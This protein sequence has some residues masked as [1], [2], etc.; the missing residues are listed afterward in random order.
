MKQRKPFQSAVLSALGVL[1]FAVGPA[2]G[3]AGSDKTNGSP[4]DIDVSF[5]QIFRAE[6]DPA[7]PAFSYREYGVDLEWHVVLLGFEHREYSWRAGVKTDPWGSL[8]RLS[9][10]LQ[11]YRTFNDT[12]GVWALCYAMAGFEDDITSRSW[13]YNPQLIG[14]YARTEPLIFYLG[15]GA[16]YHPVDPVYYPILGL[17]WNPDTETGWSGSLGFP[18]TI[19]RY[20]FSARWALKADFHW[21]IRTYRLADDNPAAPGGYMRSEDLIPGLHAA[22]YPAGNLTLTAGAR[23]H[24]HRSLQLYDGDERKLEDTDVDSAW[25]MMITARYVF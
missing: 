20:R 12:W 13:T 3:V 7:L 1:S 9:P 6:P 4:V 19:I 18:D 11:Y 5:E 22:F 10:G 17:A 15:A 16:L 23:R 25:S 14:L 21:E 24:L 8:T 2:V